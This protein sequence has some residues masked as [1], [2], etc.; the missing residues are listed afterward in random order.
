MNRSYLT[1]QVKFGEFLDQANF[2]GEGVILSINIRQ[3][4][5][6]EINVSNAPGSSSKGFYFSIE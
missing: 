2:L 5:E 4:E 6:E 1:D 3:S